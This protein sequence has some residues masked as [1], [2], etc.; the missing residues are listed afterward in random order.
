MPAGPDE[1]DPWLLRMQ[2]ALDETVQDIRL[3]DAFYG[4]FAILANTCA[5]GA[6]ILKPPAPLVRN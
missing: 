1:R 5:T 4:Q 3:R 6:S 2:L